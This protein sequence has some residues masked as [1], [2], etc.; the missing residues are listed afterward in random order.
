[1]TTFNFWAYFG[2]LISA[3]TFTAYQT[4]K[5]KERCDED[6][7]KFGGFLISVLVILLILLVKY[8]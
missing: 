6:E 1:M 8:K 7:A 2:F 3:L 5:W 4:G